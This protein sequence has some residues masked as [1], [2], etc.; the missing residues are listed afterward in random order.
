M[1]RLI[2]C[3]AAAVLL[4]IASSAGASA[5]TPIPGDTYLGQGSNFPNTY[6]PAALVYD[7]TTQ[8]LGGPS[9]EGMNWTVTDTLLPA[10]TWSGGLPTNKGS[11]PEFAGEGTI[12]AFAWTTED[13]AGYNNDAGAW[14][15][16][17]ADLDFGAGIRLLDNT[18]F[19]YWSR[20]GEPIVVPDVVLALFDAEVGPHPTDPAVTQVIYFRDIDDPAYESTS[21]P[22]GK[23][24]FGF[25]DD[26]ELN[27]NVLQLFLG[28]P[29]NGLH[30]GLMV[31]P[32]PAT[33]VLAAFGLLSLL[34]M[35]RRWSGR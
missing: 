29:L 30:M 24:M 25:E 7:G 18:A 23:F 17:T 19:A 3:L 1:T 20:D 14:A 10:G 12:M 35:G 11:I 33:A 16:L 6:G 31:V 28:E 8:P 2:T 21:F 5:P 4:V 32:E 22:D 34:A 9:P 13:D 15:V 26:G 27:S